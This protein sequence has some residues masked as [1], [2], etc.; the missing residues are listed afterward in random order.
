MP[1]KNENKT[2]TVGEKEFKLQHP[3]VKWCLD[4]DYNCR[5]RNGNIKQSEFVQG[6]LE[7]VVVEPVDFKV[8]DFNSISEVEE[9][10]QKVRKFL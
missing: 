1:K 6:F 3:G 8:D 2:I 4:H 9:F 10:Q 5:D 7:M